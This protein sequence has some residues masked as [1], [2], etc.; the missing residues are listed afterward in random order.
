MADEEIIHSFLVGLGWKNDQAGERKFVSAIEGAT[1]EA[2]LFAK[3]VEYLAESVAKNI[4]AITEKYQGIYNLE[5]IT[6]TSSETILGLRFAFKQ[7]GLG[8]GEADSTLKNVADSIRTLN[9]GTAAYFEKFGINYNKMTGGITTNF[10]QGQTNLRSMSDAEVKIYEKM[11]GLSDDMVQ[12]I[13]NRGGEMQD[14]I[15]QNKQMMKEFGIDEATVQKNKEN[16]QKIQGFWHALGLEMDHLQTASEQPF[17]DQLD[18]L[19]VWMET[20]APFF[21]KW[22]DQQVKNFDTFF[23]HS[24]NIEAMEKTDREYA[25]KQKQGNVGWME[26]PIGAAMG[27][28]NRRGGIEGLESRLTA[29]APGPAFPERPQAPP[30]PDWPPGLDATTRMN[31]ER[32]RLNGAA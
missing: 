23:M 17:T 31:L 18:G 24:H 10:R 19:R 3:A 29:P 25:E 20:S 32:R 13:R 30:Q 15:D 27:E 8:A 2:N 11:T 21:N 5:S 16:A 9:G 12:D 1:F 6:K 7:M 26:D 28:L 22:F 4:G 14:F